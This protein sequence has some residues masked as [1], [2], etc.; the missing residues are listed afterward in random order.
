MEIPAAGVLQ[1]VSI[2]PVWILLAGAPRQVVLR[3]RTD[4]KI[5]LDRFVHVTNC[6]FR[7][8]FQEVNLTD[9]KHKD[10]RR[11]DWGIGADGD[12]A[13]YDVPQCPAGT[14]ASK[15]THTITGTWM[16]VKPKS[17]S[18][19]VS[20]RLIASHAHC[21]V[22][23][24]TFHHSTASPHAVMLHSFYKWLIACAVAGTHLHTRGHV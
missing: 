22:S 4:L 12:H 2:C 16:P 11:T 17:P 14:P 21:H 3:H 20:T 6:R 9:V 1:K 18:S 13:E 7:I 8:Y 5:S 24:Q 19:N 23:H 10:I 15:C